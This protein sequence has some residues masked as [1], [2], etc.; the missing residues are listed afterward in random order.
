MSNKRSRKQFDDNEDIENINKKFK[1]NTS[2]KI[3]PN[4]SKQFIESKEDLSR[5]QLLRSQIEKFCH[6]PFFSKVAIGCYVKIA[7]GQNSNVPTYRVYNL[8]F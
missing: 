3:D 7:I 5:I 6:A 1:S 8:I 2:S 4:A